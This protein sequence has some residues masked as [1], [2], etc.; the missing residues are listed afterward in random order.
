MI[1]ITELKNNN[2]KFKEID[3]FFYENCDQKIINHFYL[4]KEQKYNFNKKC[5]AIC[6]ETI[7]S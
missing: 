2:K 1:L 6:F 4:S 3:S 7:C 5:D